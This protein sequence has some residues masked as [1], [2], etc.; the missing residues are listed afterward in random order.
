M[1]LAKPKFWPAFITITEE[2]IQQSSEDLK[3]ER[4]E[5]LPRFPGLNRDIVNALKP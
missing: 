5:W 4:L 3:Q 1:F 2:Q